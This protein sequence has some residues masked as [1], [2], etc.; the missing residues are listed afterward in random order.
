MPDRWTPSSPCAVV[1]VDPYEEEP[2]TIVIDGVELDWALAGFDVI[3]VWDNSDSA[4]AAYQSG[5][6]GARSNVGNRFFLRL[7]N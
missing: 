6:I 3:D 5:A 7:L 1:E 2:M 4:S